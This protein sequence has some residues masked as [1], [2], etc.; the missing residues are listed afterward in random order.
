MREH[1]WLATD[2][3]ADPAEELVDSD[4]LGQPASLADLAERLLDLHPERLGEQGVVADLGV[5][6]E[7]EVVRREVQ[8]GGEERLEPSTLAPV[9]P[10]G[11]VPPEHAVVDDHELGAGRRRPLEELDRGG[12]AARDL[13]HL[14]GAEHLQAGRAVLREAVDFEQLV[15]VPDDLVALGHGLDYRYPLRA[16]GVAQPGSALRSGRRGPEFESPHPDERGGTARFPHELPSDDRRSS[17][18]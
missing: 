5:R 11:L 17:L 13:R 4:R 12:D 6:V 1:E 10:D 14:V 7:R 18:R 15:R 8:V 16:R 2:G 3:L 9:D